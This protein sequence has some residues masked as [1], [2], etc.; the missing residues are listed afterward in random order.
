MRLEKNGKRRHIS[1]GRT[2]AHARAH[3]HMQQA[4]DTG[5][6]TRTHTHTTIDTYI[7]THR[8]LLS[9]TPSPVVC[10]S[11]DFAALLPFAKNL[12]IAPCALAPLP[13]LLPAPLFS[14]GCGVKAGVFVCLCVCVCVC[15][16]LNPVLTFTRGV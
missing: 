10:F 5:I 1:V 16:Y 14:P 4:S 2:H 6:R 7:D 3:T 11:S 13:L 15:V 12:A 9:Y 8:G